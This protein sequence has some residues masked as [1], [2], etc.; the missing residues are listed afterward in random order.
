MVT[1]ILSGLLL[2]IVHLSLFQRGVSM[3]C[4]VSR[5]VAARWLAVSLCTLRLLMTALA[6]FVLIGAGCS[7][8]GLGAGLLT[9]LYVYRASLLIARVPK[10][11]RV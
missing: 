5:P 9:A 4:A 6:G 7:P 1:G 11:G 3:A 10:E 2:G 8:V